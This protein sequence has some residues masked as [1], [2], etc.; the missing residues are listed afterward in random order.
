MAK[1]ECECGNN[2]FYIEFP[3]PHAID[4]ICTKC[5]NKQKLEE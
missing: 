5:G 2:T 3:V 4:G 1:L